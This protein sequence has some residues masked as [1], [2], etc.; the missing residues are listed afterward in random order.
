M[1]EQKIACPRC[2]WEPR[3]YHTWICSCFH[4]WNT[5]DTGGRCP[6]CR[7][8]WE[9]THCPSCQEWSP[10]LDWYWDL[11]DEL[12]DALAEVEESLKIPR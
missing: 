6:N 9:H 5:F 11:D 3:A 8:Q 10:H 12:E 4:T 1:A 7:K 2:A